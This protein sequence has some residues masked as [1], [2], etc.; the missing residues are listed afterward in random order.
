MFGVILGLGMGCGMLV[1]RVVEPDLGSVPAELPHQKISDL[2]VRT[3]LMGRIETEPLLDNCFWHS[4]VPAGR[5]QSTG[6]RDLRLGE[7][8]MG[9][10]LNYFIHPY[11]EMDGLDASQRLESSYRFWSVSG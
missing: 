9:A 5:A 2:E 3:S 6:G 1:S 7:A 4:Q 10:P 8:H 11:E